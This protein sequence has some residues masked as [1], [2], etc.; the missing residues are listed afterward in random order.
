MKLSRLKLRFQGHQHVQLC[1]N[2]VHADLSRAIRRRRVLVPP[3]SEFG[4][5]GAQALER[6][7]HREGGFVHDFLFADFKAEFV[8]NAWHLISEAHCRI[9][10]KI[11]IAALLNWLDLL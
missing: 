11:D 10:Q 4:F 6:T 2:I 5:E 7:D 8:N 9:H 3:N 1:I